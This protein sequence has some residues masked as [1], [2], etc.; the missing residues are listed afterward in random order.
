MNKAIFFDKDGTLIPNIPYNVDPE[1]IALYGDAFTGL[2]ELYEAG[3]KIFITTNQSGLAKGLFTSEDLAQVKRKM[4]RLL[5]GLG[6]PLQGFYYCPH[7]ENG[8]V[9]QYARPCRCRK[10]F[11][12]LILQAAGEHG[13]D[14]S[15]S[16]MIGDIL[17]DVEAG[18][19]AGCQS[20]L[21]DKGYETLWESG[22]YRQ[23]RFIARSIDEAAR[24]IL[25]KNT[26]S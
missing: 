2:K 26:S 6:V 8:R 24:L 18:N 7:D 19:Q 9:S 17:N 20:V 1:R 16:W 3:Y 21:I 10:P 12:G 23:P 5:E 14:L 15:S 22:E 4:E 13:I 11:P 25:N